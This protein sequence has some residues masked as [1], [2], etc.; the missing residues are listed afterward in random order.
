VRRH[1][2][3]PDL[4]RGLAEA[5]ES[6]GDLD[7]AL[8]LLSQAVAA[9]PD[10]SGLR[11][12]L[13]RLY[14]KLKRYDEASAQAEILLKAL[15]GNPAAGDQDVEVRSAQML[16]IETYGSAGKYDQAIA[17]A[18]RAEHDFPREFRF[19]F[20]RAEL[21]L[22]AGREK[23]AEAVFAS[24]KQKSG[25]D[26]MV[27]AGISEVFFRAGTV[28]ERNGSYK[29]AEEFLRRAI[30]ADAENHAAMNYL[31]YL[32]ADRGDNLDES[33]ELIQRALR[34]DEGNG[35]Y[36]DSLG[37]TLFRLQRFALA[38]GPLKEATK[39]MPDEPVVH[40]HLGDLYWA[41]GRRDEAVQSWQ[42]ALR[43]GSTDGAAIRKKISRSPP[44]S[45]PD[46]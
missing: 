23:D 17:A 46:P 38:E 6:A 13:A 45:P 10:R 2:E 44:S 39:A 18:A 7:G 21:L 3:N 28:E 12:Q 36:L 42:E 4:Q 41:L 9:S 22:E 24:M 11:F 40:D 27:R 1:P 5:M 15:N 31:G 30:D 16:L 19:P 29:R 25:S 14:L 43:L 37:W 33:L 34:L 8:A 20:K 26:A 35:A 32:M